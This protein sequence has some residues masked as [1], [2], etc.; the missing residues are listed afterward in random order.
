[1]EKTKEKKAEPPFEL[2]YRDWKPEYLYSL[3]ELSTFFREII[4]NK[5]LLASKC[6]QCG[7]VWMFPR[8]DCPDCYEETEW[9]PITGEGTIVSCSYVYFIGHGIDLLSYL[10]VPFVYA[11]IHLD[12]T[13]TYIP[14]CVKPPSQKM[15][16]IRTGTRVKAVF[17]ENRRGTIGD[18]YFVP[19]QSINQNV[20]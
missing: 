1:M 3:G 9:V 13:D 17:R 8:G 2:E 12:G 16:D 11:L 6:P 5:R 19:I 4:N 15:G 10:D 20:P 18:F 14:H 7:K